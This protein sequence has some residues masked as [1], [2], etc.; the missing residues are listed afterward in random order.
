MRRAAPLLGSAIALTALC[1]FSV[2]PPAAADCNPDTALYSDDFEE[3]MDANWGE[4]DDHLFVKDGALVA[5]S[6]TGVVNFATRGTDINACLDVTIVK[7]PDPDYTYTGMVFWW[8]NWDNYYYVFYWPTGTVNIWRVLKGK[9]TYLAEAH[10]ANIKKGVGQT[11][12]LELDLKGKTATFLVNGQVASRL[13]GIPPK[14]A[15]PV[16]LIAGAPEDKQAT[17]KFDNFI[18]SEPAQ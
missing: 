16:G 8:T 12:R 11:N 14:D 18:V 10:P 13:K 5:K 6:Y 7:A 9:D 3:F 15:S 2:A 17:F 4:A 1:L